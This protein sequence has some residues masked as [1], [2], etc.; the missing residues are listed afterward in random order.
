MSIGNPVHSQLNQRIGE[1]KSYMAHSNGNF[2]TQS[3]QYVFFGTNGGIVQINKS[4][5]EVNLITKVEGLS[6]ISVQ[7]LAFDP[8]NKKLIIAYQNSNLDIYDPVDLTVIN[9]PDILNNTRILGDRIIYRIYQPPGSDEAYLACGFGIVELNVNKKEFGF[10]SFTGIPVYETTIFKNK[11]YAVTESGT[12]T[13]PYDKTQYNLSDFGQW[14]IEKTLGNNSF[15][16]IQSFND[17][18]YIGTKSKI[19][20]WDGNS[21]PILIEDL[22]GFQNQYLSAHNGYLLI[23]YTCNDNCDG[24]LFAIDDQNKLMNLES[25]C[26]PRPLYGIVDEKK[27]GWFADRFQAFRSNQ[28]LTGPCNY[29]YFNTPLT[30]YSTDIAL[31]HGKVY[32]ASGGINASYSYLFRGDGFFSFADGIWRVFNRG[33]NTTM[34]NADLVDLYKLAIDPNG[35]LYIGTYWGGLMQCDM[36]DPANP[37]IKLFDKSNSSLQGTTGDLA[38]TRVGGLTFDQ[39]GNLWMT[40]YLAERP[41]SV[42]KKDGTWKNFSTP[43]NTTLLACAADSAG[44][45]WFSSVKQGLLVM[46][47]GKDIN[48]TGDDR[49]KL[50]TNA[51][52]VLA[53]NLINAIATDLDGSVW[54]GTDVGVYV[55]ECGSDVFT[56]CTGSKRIV[57]QQDLGS[58]LLDKED[59]QCIAIDGG[60]RKW[61]GTRHGVFVVSSGGDQLEHQYNIDNSPL[62]DNLITALRYDGTSGEMFIGTGSGVQSIRTEATQGSLTNQ[63]SDIYVFPNPVRPEYNGPISIQGMRRNSHIKITNFNGQ[64][65]SQGTSNG[66]TY[67]WDGLDLK[68]RKVDSGVYIVWISAG[69]GFESADVKSVK[70]AIVR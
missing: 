2:V 48:N 28:T 38:R 32:I 3:D 41:V 11:L 53:T 50:F 40:N 34:A 61:F 64:L 52:S 67:L 62:F 43:S 35:L 39:N 12:Y 59:I 16:C 58:N 5:E 46:N 33:N 4:T 56:N 49:Y 69:D 27:R 70:F 60:N 68:G 13:I 8:K 19:Y 57:V 17:A 44:N 42:L 45:L 30:Q 14:S 22:P 20:R 36:K 26:V 1:W 6:D 25:S 24:K 54:I 15:Q 31:D 29:K 10:T 21:A 18:L 23:G 51:N 37:I 7:A 65:V 66:G 63:Y 55:F 9:L 47:T